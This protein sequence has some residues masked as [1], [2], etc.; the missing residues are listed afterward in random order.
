MK[1]HLQTV[2]LALCAAMLAVPLVAQ[3]APKAVA[4]Q[5]I[6]DVGI[7]AKGDKITADFEIRNDGNA[8]LEIT[9]VK[10]GCGC[11]VASFDKSIAPGKTGKVHAVVDT[12]AFNGAIA[13]GVAVLT[14]DKATPKI[15]LTVK[16][17]I[18]PY[19]DVKPGYARYLVVRGESK[20]GNIVQTLW[21]ADGA[22]FDVV[23]VESPFPYLTVSFRE[24]QEGERDSAGKGKQWRVE[25]RLSNETS[26]VGPLAGYVT[27]HTN[28]HKQKVVEIPIT[29]FVRP[30]IAVTPPVGDFGQI[31]LK[32]P[33]QK[34]LMVRSFSTE[35]I[36]LTKVDHEGK[37][38]DAALV[39]LEE[40]RSY[41][42]KVTLNPAMGKGPFHSKLTIHTDSPKAPIVEVELKG[43][44]I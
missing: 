32:Q 40:G 14:N 33:L 42:V 41:Q 6:K 29:G 24:A 5:P 22:P 1:R 35:P 4:I 28:H 3:G 19:I 2:I 13:K 10:P 16:A 26:P 21:A 31:E 9:D 17:R 38:I 39:A 30:V 34:N 37:G 18:E 7:V 12:A 11:T 43:T 23:K 15:D 20:E 27:V 36:K 8:P 25:T 44:V